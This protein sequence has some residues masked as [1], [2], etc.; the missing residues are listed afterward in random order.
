MITTFETGTERQYAMRMFSMLS[1]AVV[2]MLAMVLAGCV[3]KPPRR[4]GPSPENGSPSTPQA[5]F[6]A[7]PTSGDMPLTVQFTDLSTGDIAQWAWDFDSDGVADS[8]EQNPTYEYSKNGTYTVSLTVTGTDSSSDTATKN[9]HITVSYPG[10][11]LSLDL[12]VVEREDDAI[13]KGSGPLKW[14]YASSIVA[15]YS[16][17]KSSSYMCIGSRYQNVTIPKGST[18]VE[19]YIQI[20]PNVNQDANFT[21]YAEAE[22]NPDDFAIT[23]AII[24]RNRT[25]A[26]VD[27]VQDRIGLLN[28]KTSPD[29][30]EVVQEVVDRPGWSS[31]NSL[32]ILLIGKTGDGTPWKL[33]SVAMVDHPGPEGTIPGPYGMRLHIEYGPP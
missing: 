10:P 3:A 22:D 13:E 15:S 20:Y 19:A 21:I 25:S 32:V 4:D 6:A 2:I 1:I 33:C 7:S 14:H 31:G 16:D 18:V 9:S 27:W 23:P 17:D 24:G 5:D 8:T 11:T 26:G 28:W 30:R 12:Q 29:I